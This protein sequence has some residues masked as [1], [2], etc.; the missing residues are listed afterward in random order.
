MEIFTFSLPS[1]ETSTFF[2]LLGPRPICA[3]AP[4]LHQHYIAKSN[5]PSF[6]QCNYAP[7]VHLHHIRTSITLRKAITPCFP[8]CNYARKNFKEKLRPTCQAGILPRPRPTHAE[9][10]PYPHRTQRLTPP[11]FASPCTQ[12]CTLPYFQTL[13][14]SHAC[15][16]NCHLLTEPPHD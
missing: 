10:A 14:S 8:E 1:F 16:A 6:P 11:A 5:Q 12:I 7:H 3:P 9:T 15:H 2:F 13:T 4:H